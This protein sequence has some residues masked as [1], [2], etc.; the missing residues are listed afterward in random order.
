MLAAAAARAGPDSSP[1]E[2]R[3]VAGV[4]KMAAPFFFSRGTLSETSDALALFKRIM[5]ELGSA[6]PVCPL[7]AQR[8]YLAYVGGINIALRRAVLAGGLSVSFVLQL[9]SEW[10]RCFTAAF[11]LGSIE[12]RNIASA[13][14]AALL[15]L[16]EASV[17][18]AGYADIIGA[19][20]QQLR[21]W[22]AVV[23]EVVPGEQRCVLSLLQVIV[24]RNPL[25]P[26]LLLAVLQNLSFETVEAPSGEDDG[27]DFVDVLCASIRSLEI[28]PQNLHKRV[29]QQLLTHLE[30][31]H[32]AGVS[33]CAVVLHI[34]ARLSSSEANE[35]FMMIASR[36]GAIPV[37]LVGG[38]RGTS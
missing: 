25:D 15:S 29:V 5:T 11:P 6:K 22:A 10:F 9:A 34:L 18:Q 36:P 31:G 16:T 32:D 33:E 23:D 14:T 38:V 28:F 24:D 13:M 8:A 26:L 20:D 3:A 1:R 2:I 7:L 21:H 37:W 17:V 19:A 27:G 4:L 35:V 12:N 30:A